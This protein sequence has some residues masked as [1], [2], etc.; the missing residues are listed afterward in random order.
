MK[1]IGNYNTQQFLMKS[2]L[3]KFIQNYNR[4]GFHIKSGQKDLQ[5]KIY[6]VPQYG[7]LQNIITTFFNE[8]LDINQR[9]FLLLK[10]Q[11]GELGWRTFHHGIITSRSYFSNYINF[12]QSQLDITSEEY[13]NEDDYVKV[14]FHYFIIPK[15]RWNQFPM[16]KW[17][18]I[19]RKPSLV[20]KIDDFH[21][22]YNIPINKDYSSWGDITF[23][24]SQIMIIEGNTNYMINIDTELK[25]NSIF[26]GK[27]DIK[28]T[29]QILNDRFFK[30]T[31]KDYTY[32]IDSKEQKIVLSLNQIK[33][34][35]LT[36]TNENP[37][38]MDPNKLEERNKERLM[39][40]KIGT[41]DIETIVR[42]GVHSSYLYSFYDGTKTYSFFGESPDDPQPSLNMLRQMLKSKYNAYTFYA[43][44]FTGFDINFMLS[45]ISILEREG[46]RVT[47]MKN[48]D[49]Y[50]NISISNKAKR[51]SINLRDSLLILPM[52]LSKLGE[53]FSVDVLKSI[54]PV[55]SNP[56]DLLN[57]FM[58]KDLTHYNKEVEIISSFDDWKDKIRKYCETDCISLYQIIIKFRILVFEKWHLFIENY[59]TTPS[60]A[61]AIFRRHYLED[62]LLPIYKG[63]VF[64]FLRAS[65]TGGSTEMYKPYGRNINCYDANSLYPSTM[66]INKFPVGQTYEFSGDINLLYELDGIIW[67]IDNSYFIADV[68]VETNKDLYQPYIQVNHLSKE[69]GLPDNRNI[70]PNGSFNMKINSCELHNAV[71]SGDYNITSTQGYLWFSKP[72]FENFVNDIYT[73]RNIYPKTDPM[74]LIC[75]L[76]LNSV[77]GRFA[78]KPIISKTEFISRDLNIYE[79]INKNTIE[80]FIDVDKDNILITYRNN[81][82]NGELDVEYNNSIATAS[83]ITAYARVFMSQFKNNP[84]FKLLYT[85]TDS[86]FIEGELPE[87]MIGTELGKFKLEN[88]FK[89]IVFLGPKIYSG[90][91]L[92]GKTI[93]KIKGFKDSKTLSFGDI[94]SLLIKDS[95]LKL[96]HIKWF[97][98][99]NN[100]QMKEQPY[101]LSTTMNKREIIYREG[102]AVDTKAFKLNNNNI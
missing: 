83:A 25:I 54:E 67:N 1:F 59:P 94:K 89:E 91:T 93:T 19:A 18:H 102:V 46:Y 96:K 26:C 79:F 74:N 56:N 31:F 87:N 101:A 4:Q 23:S 100:I 40:P 90:I 12:V 2:S 73:L 17:M 70:S 47:F 65:F 5:L 42:D 78:M 92:S 49:K 52:G 84:S 88:Q 14:A 13:K 64:D 7:S 27:D 57:P 76:I 21:S 48:N 86:V 99:L 24:S 97:R 6:S 55:Y 20:I 60:L 10:V 51:V 77:Y 15:D 62:G 63:K 35:F 44:N 72:I 50:I 75:K 41:F 11:L 66:A 81:N 29:D 82:E 22:K 8:E 45:S 98:T 80:D 36:S 43:H 16:E 9:Y 95:I 69:N 3:I 38:K 85:D 71:N 33:T 32:Y 30:R 28:F 58:M 37:Y 61:F 68:K 34:D 39:I 53:Q